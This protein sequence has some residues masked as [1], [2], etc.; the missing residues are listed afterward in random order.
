MNKEFPE[1]KFY[2]SDWLEGHDHGDLEIESRIDIYSPG[3]LSMGKDPK[4][5][6]SIQ[7][8]RLRKRDETNINYFFSHILPKIDLDPLSW[9]HIFYITNDLECMKKG[10]F[11]LYAKGEARS[12]IHPVYEED[13]IKKALEI[14]AK[15]VD[16]KVFFKKS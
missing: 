16:P 6:R 11:V 13:M 3:H 9:R 7:A 5:G 14:G 8:A 1:Q 4:R 12:W 10:G 15:E 2:L